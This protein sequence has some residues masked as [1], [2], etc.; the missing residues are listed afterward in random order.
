MAIEAARASMADTIDHSALACKRL[1]Y[2]RAMK[3]VYLFAALLGAV[4]PWSYNLRAFEEM[5]AEF[6]P[7]AFVAQGFQGSAMLGS[8]AADFW[9]GSCVA[10]VWMIVEARRLGMRHWW[11]FLIWTFAV[12][13]ASALPLFLYFRERKL[14]EA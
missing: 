7:Q 1:C 8:L 10:L 13:W 3:Y 11:A 14:A 4:V 12:A 9:I 5:G 6:T 2:V